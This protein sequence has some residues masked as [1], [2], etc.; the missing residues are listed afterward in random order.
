MR[1]QGG[2][3]D[4]DV[5]D[6]RGLGPARIGGGIGLGG[7]VI[8]LIA[9]FV[10]GIDP[11]ALLSAD[12]GA[13]SEQ[14]QGVAG[15]PKDA[16]GAFADTVF[17]SVNRSWAAQFQREGRVWEKPVLVL[18]DQ[19]TTTACG[20]GQAAMGPFYCPNDRKVYLDLGFFR[21]LESRFGASGEFARAYVIAHEVGHHVQNL[22]GISEKAEEAQ[23]AA[24]SRRGA[25]RVSVR[26]ELQ[27][28]CYAGVWAKSYAGTGRMEDGDI[29]SAISA[30]AAVGD[31]RLQRESQGVVMPDSF[32]HGS[33]A[34][35]TEWFRRGWSSGDPAACDTFSG[36]L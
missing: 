11:R 16:E 9:Y 32:T 23:Q 26:V 10:F 28:D 15:S 29:D 1:W 36:S 18:Y 21:E 12:P 19:A 4:G 3:R 17:T 2:E 14:Q 31:D 8:V 25:N 13:G 20:F 35:R 22:E 33:A 34:Q 7:V 5:E 6:R 24:G 30:A 27:A